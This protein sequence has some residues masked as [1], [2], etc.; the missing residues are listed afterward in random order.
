MHTVLHDWPDDKALQILK[1][2]AEAMEP[3]YSSVLLH[4]SVISA[5]RAD[6]RVCTS[7]LTMMMSFSAAERTEVMWKGLIESAGLKL[8]KTWAQPTSPESILELEKES[9]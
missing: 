2:L 7:D 9:A 5:F 6:P 3:G 8:V 1:H 4:E